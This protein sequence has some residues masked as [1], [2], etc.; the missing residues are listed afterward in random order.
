M[1]SV[2][3]R[4]GKPIVKGVAVSSHVVG[5]SVESCGMHASYK[6]GPTVESAPAAHSSGSHL[7]EIALAAGQ[8]HSITATTDI[9]AAQLR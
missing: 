5:Y 7:V 3:P 6:C 2:P 4:G 9:C 1:M 8:S